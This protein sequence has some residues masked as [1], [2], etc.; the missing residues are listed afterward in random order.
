MLQGP[1]RQTTYSR[2]FSGFTK[3]AVMTRRFTEE[4][5]AARVLA[6]KAKW[7]ANNRS[8]IHAYDRQRTLDPAHR[9]KKM[10]LQKLRRARLAALQGSSRVH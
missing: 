5:A 7:R 4:E 9:V 8:K 10:L 2:T 3:E 1:A 6:S